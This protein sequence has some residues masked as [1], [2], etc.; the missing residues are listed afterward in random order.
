MGQ[1]LAKLANAGLGEE[2][3]AEEE[4]VISN[5]ASVAFQGMCHLVRPDTRCNPLKAD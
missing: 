3:R 2:A 1:L 5:V 4:D